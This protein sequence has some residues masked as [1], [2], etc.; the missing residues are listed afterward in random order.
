MSAL[1]FPPSW[2]EEEEESGTPPKPPTSSW[3]LAIPIPYR[4][5]DS[6]ISTTILSMMALNILNTTFSFLL[7]LEVSILNDFLHWK[8]LVGN[9][10][11]S[12]LIS[13]SSRNFDLILVMVCIKSQRFLFFSMSLIKFCTRRGTSWVD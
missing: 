2:K 5:S 6:I 10:R 8:Q 3:L 4:T 12:F 13:T 11:E 7:S 1:F 9:E